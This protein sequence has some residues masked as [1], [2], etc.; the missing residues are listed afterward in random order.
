CRTPDI[1]V[2]PVRPGDVALAS[3][4]VLKLYADALNQHH[5]AVPVIARDVQRYG[6]LRIDPQHCSA[7]GHAV[8]GSSSAGICTVS[9]SL[10]ATMARQAAM[11][12]VS[13]KTTGM[14]A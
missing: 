9:P 8:H 14:P 6:A 10:A 5:D 13:P 7:F 1:R 2:I 12:W 4:H 11:R 3:L